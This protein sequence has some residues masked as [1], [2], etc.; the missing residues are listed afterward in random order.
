VKVPS[1]KRHALHERVSLF[2]LSS[3][4]NKPVTDAARCYFMGHLSRMVF[5]KSLDIPLN[6]Q[7]GLTRKAQIGRIYAKTN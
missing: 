7:Q 2:G 3:A 6:L 1:S 5:A 4:A